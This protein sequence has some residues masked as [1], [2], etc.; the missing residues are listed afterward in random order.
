M[1]F[2]YDKNN[3]PASKALPFP[4][5]EVKEGEDRGAGRARGELRVGSLIGL[6]A[7]AGRLSRRGAGCGTVGIRV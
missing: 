1:N 3:S 4:V 6:V 7:V 2:N 5:S